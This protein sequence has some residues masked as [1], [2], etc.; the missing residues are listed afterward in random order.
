[1]TIIL[2]GPLRQQRNKELFASIMHTR[3]GGVGCAFAF[4][5]QAE[6]KRHR[7]VA[8]HQSLSTLE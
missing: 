6:N 3:R 5:Q 2:H 1:M 8:L 4:A 7:Q